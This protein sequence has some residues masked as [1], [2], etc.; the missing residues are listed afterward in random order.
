MD[1]AIR[2]VKKKASSQDCWTSGHFIGMHLMVA[3]LH[4]PSQMFCQSTFGSR[5][6]ASGR[7]TSF[8]AHMEF[9]LS[10]ATVTNQDQTTGMQSSGCHCA[11]YLKPCTGSRHYEGIA[12]C[13]L[14][15][16]YGIRCLV[17]DQEDLH[18]IVNPTKPFV[19]CNIKQI[20]RVE[21]LPAGTQ[22]QSL[23]DTLQAVG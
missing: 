8:P 21:P 22:R 20:F 10:H 5:N 4:L 3:R 16:K 17:K 13:H 6:P 11:L 2:P 7:S 18:R 9:S 1:F 19:S 14:G 23:V 12:V 15:S